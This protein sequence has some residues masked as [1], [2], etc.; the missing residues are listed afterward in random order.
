MVDGIKTDWLKFYTE[1]D[2]FITSELGMTEDKQIG[3]Y[4]IKFRK[5][6]EPGEIIKDKLLQYL[7]DD[8]QGVARKMYAEKTL[9]LKKF[10]SY[11]MLYDAFDK[12]E[13]VF[14]DEFTSR[15]GKS[16]KAAADDEAS[17]QND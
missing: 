1:L 15:L 12:G 11:S 8:V 7:W 13:N 5:Y 14:S 9:F 3:P 4:F 2:K 17:D 10:T 16:G 6:D